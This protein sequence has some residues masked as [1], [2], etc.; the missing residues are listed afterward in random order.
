MFIKPDMFLTL[1]VVGAWSSPASTATLFVAPGQSQSA[2]RDSVYSSIASAVEDLK[3]GDVLVLKPGV[4]R[5]SIIL[6][7]GRRGGTRKGLTIRGEDKDAVVIK[8]S[9]VVEGFAKFR[10]DIYVKTNWPTEPQQVFVNGRPLQQQGGTVFGGYPEDKKLPIYRQFKDRLWPGRRPG[11]VGAMP[12][13]SFTYDREAKALYIRVSGLADPGDALIEV[14][15][16]PFLL[17]AKGWDN[18]KIQDISFR[19]SNTSTGG[20][21]GAVS[22]WGD[23]HVLENVDITDV[24]SVGLH[25]VGDDIEVSNCNISRAGRLGVLARGRRHLYQNNTTNSNNTRGFNKYWEA[26]GMKFVGDGGLKD[27]AVTRHTA[28]RN[29]GDGIWFDW[30]NENNQVTDSIVAYNEGFGIHY[31]A[32]VGARIVGNLAFANRHRGIYLPHSSHNV[33]MCNLASLNGMEGIVVVDEGRRTKDLDLEPR[34]NRIIGNIMA[35]NHRKQ[36]ARPALVLPQND[37]ENVSNWN[38]YVSDSP[39]SLF[40]RGWPKVGN[41][42]VRGLPHWQQVSGQ[43][44]HSW[45]RQLAI[46]ANVERA[47]AER[48]EDVDWSSLERLATEYGI[49]GSTEADQVGCVVPGPFGRTHAN[50]RSP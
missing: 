25:L 46:P 41:P 10:D 29:E 36:R 43:D 13:R 39:K 6:E 9:D 17:L 28:L 3:P 14:S 34:D 11:G 18:I 24:D 40:S 4:Y 15:V 8:G 38:L 21:N 7:S 44:V 33:V 47:Y 42:V 32:S 19:H 48:R 5:E 50:S 1:A 20:R 27:S 49:T 2:G 16:R 22:L 26:G 30:L 12:D 23:G 37:A 35:W 31:E 45:S